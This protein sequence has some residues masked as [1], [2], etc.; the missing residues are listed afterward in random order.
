MFEYSSPNKYLF[1]AELQAR[2]DSRS[3]Q[4]DHLV[5]FLGGTL[6]LSS[7][8]TN[9]PNSQA[10]LNWGKELTK[11]CA[12][13]YFNNDKQGLAPEIVYFHS[14]SDKSA[15]KD[16]EIHHQDR[17]S[18]L[19]PETVESIFY[20]WRITHDEKYRKWGYEIFKN[21][22][23]NAR[24]SNGYASIDDVTVGK[25]SINYRDSMESFFLAETMKYLY[26]LF[27]EDDFV[28]LDKYVFNTEAHPLPILTK[29]QV[30]KIFPL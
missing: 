8:N 17:F 27:C 23:N 21:F 15:T 12:S 6:A 16:F 25:A 14:Q 9:N 30:H 10:H 4:F 3:S 11:T 1:M 2:S 28:G 13:I 29:D 26:L 7:L 20:L 5:C 22:R 18:L 19:R 24:V